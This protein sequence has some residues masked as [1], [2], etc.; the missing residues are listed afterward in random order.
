MAVTEHQVKVYMS[1]RGAGRSQGAAAAKAGFSER[2]GRRVEQRGD[3]GHRPEPRRWR[4]REDPFTAVWEAELEPMLAATPAL[5]AITRLEWL[6]EREP[7]RYPDSLLRT[8]QRR[9]KAWRALHGPDREVMFR[10][11]HE[12]GQRGLSDFTQLTGVTITVGGTPLVHRLYHF[13]LAY[14]GW[15]DVTVVRGGE[16][17]PALAA[18]LQRALARL[19]G[20]PREHRTDSLSAAFKNLTAV[21]QEDLTTRYAALC[22]HYGMAASRNH[23][24]R[25]HENGSIESPH[26]HLKRRIV[27][28]LLLRGSSDFDTVADYQAF[29]DQVTATIRR[30][31]RTPIEAE[32]PHLRPLPAT[33]AVDYDLL[34]LR[35]STCSTIQ[36]RRVTYTVPA[37]L[38]GERLNVH[39]FDD[40]LELYHGTT[41]V[42]TLHRVYPTSAQHRARCIDYRHVIEWLARKPM[43]LQGLQFRDDLW[44]SEDYRQLWH[45][46]TRHHA[47]RQACKL[48]V[49]ALKLAADQDCEQALATYW[50]AALTEGASPTLADLQSRFARR[51]L[52]VVSTPVQQHDLAGYDALLAA[53]LPEPTHG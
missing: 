27:Q 40:R 6:Q 48:M 15:C 24:G 31:N 47:P 22:A 52:P 53:P 9:V 19:G 44:P 14:S 1:A 17:F 20:V 41:R 45:Q 49:G 36:V 8:L 33:P 18:G 35:V 5:Q 12:P 46:L 43:A 16:S 39:L 34:T 25:A 50:Q 32:R 37:R 13:R 7:E 26:G 51:A 2:T 38:I 28:A 21:E 23:P 29:L 10:Q 4:T 30:R 42:L 11:R 3:G